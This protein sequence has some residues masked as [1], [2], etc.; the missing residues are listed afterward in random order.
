M[1]S[2]APLLVF[3]QS[4][5]PTIL[6]TPLRPLLTATTALLVVMVITSRSIEQAPGAMIVAAV[7]AIAGSVI[8][9]LDDEA[10]STLRSSP[11]VAL[12]RLVHRLAILVPVLLVAVAA[13]VV[14]DRLLYA[15]ASPLPSPTAFVALVT[16]GVAVQVLWSRHRPD[17][18]AESAAVAIVTWALAGTLVPNVA[19]LPTIADAWLTRAPWVLGVSIVLIAAGT[20]GRDA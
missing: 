6:A 14:A 7:G 5:R 8:L 2:T 19:P 4:V 17:A 16:A 3:R 11:T 15:R 1:T 13:L 18:S 10:N 12:V 20:A 9:G